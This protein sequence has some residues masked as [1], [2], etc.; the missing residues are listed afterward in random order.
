LADEHHLNKNGKITK[1]RRISD[2]PI[3][4]YLQ[5][6]ADTLTAT[7]NEEAVLF[8]APQFKA[9]LYDWIISERVSFRVLES[10]KLYTLL[11]YLQLRCK[12]IVPTNKTISNTIYRLYD[13]ALGEVTETL[14]SSAT[15]VNIS[16]DL[17]T[18]GNKLALLGLVVSFINNA[19][20]L[21]TTLLALLRQYGRHTGANMAETIGAIIAEFGL[22]KRLRYFIT[23]N[24]KSNETCLNYLA[25]EFNFNTKQR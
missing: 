11:E 21:T 7:Q 23:D 10:E 3:D 18:S 5:N 4:S 15:N 12:A 24:A 6:G 13:K 22:R 14:Q 8:A 19:G 25:K 2:R 20:K 1:K 17:W 16:F 9:L